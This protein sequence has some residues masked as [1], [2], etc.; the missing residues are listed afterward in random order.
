MLPALGRAHQSRV[1]KRSPV[2]QRKAD[3]VLAT[4]APNI[5]LFMAIM[6][7]E[8]IINHHQTALTEFFTDTLETGHII[9]HELDIATLVINAIN[10]PGKAADC[11]LQIV[12]TCIKKLCGKTFTQQHA[13]GGEHR[14]HP[15]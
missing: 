14:S 5:T 1:G 2:T 8:D 4:K 13:V 15:L 6:F 7:K 3:A 10:L 12:K 9:Q 11:Y